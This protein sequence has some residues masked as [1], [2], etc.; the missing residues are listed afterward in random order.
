MARFR[1]HYLMVYYA[2]A[3]GVSVPFNTGAIYK[4]LHLPASLLAGGRSWLFVPAALGPLIAALV[5][6]R[7]DRTTARRVGLFG[8]D[9]LE[10]LLVALIPLVV[11][12][13]AGYVKGGVPG[14][15]YAGAS[16]CAALLYSLGEEA[17]WRGYLQDALRPLRERQRYL[18]VGALWW[19]WHARF[20]S[21][22]DWVAFPLIVIASAFV[23]GHVAEKT[24]SLLVVASMHAVIM[25]LTMNGSVGSAF[26]VAGG[27]IVLGWILVGQLRPAKPC[28]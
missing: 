14:L 2:I 27:V 3:L 28:A 21:A 19:A 9:R 26:G 24:R 17:G 15:L 25:L 23:L 7:L 18:L 16:A 6:Y 1:W 22:F 11:F 13:V 12:P 8:E 4:Y 5:C 10:S 20:A